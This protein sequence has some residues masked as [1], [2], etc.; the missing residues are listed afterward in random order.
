MEQEILSKM[1]AAISVMQRYVELGHSLSCAYSGGKDSTCTLVLMLEAIRRAGGTTITHHVQS[2]DTTIE[3][4]TIANFLHSVLD[5]LQ[6]YI[7]ASALPVHIHVTTPSLAS[8]FVV[9][10]IGRGTLVRTP[11]NGVRDGRRTRACAD[12]WKVRPGGRLR[13]LLERRAADDGAREVITVLGLR[14]DE[15]TSRAVAMAERRDSAETAVRS[16]TGALTISPLSEWTSDDVWT[17]LALLADAQTLL[18]PSPL[19]SRTILRLSEIYRAGNG[20]TCGVVMGESGA[21]AACGSRF[22]CS[23]CCVAGDRDKSLEAMIE[24]EQYGHLRPLNDFRNYLL[25]IQWD[26]SRRELIG[27]SLSDACYTRI[28]ADTYSYATRIGLLKMLISIDAA[29]RDRA[30]AHSADLAIG[31]I[32]DTE[33]NRM[34]CEPQFE[35]VTPQQLVAIDFFLSMHHYAP[36]AFPA[37]AVWHDVNVLGRRYPVPK[38][39]GLPK[40]DIVLHGWYPVGQ[41]DRDAPSVGLRSFDAEQWNPYRHP[42]RPG[43]YARTTGGEQTVYFEEATQFEVDAEAACAFVTCTYDTAFMLDTQHRDAIDSAHFWLNEGIVKL[44]TGM[45]QRYQDMAKRG[46]YFSRL[47]QRLNL[48][49]PELDAHLIENAIGDEAHQALFGC[50]TTQLSLFAEAA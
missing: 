40:T 22:G 50:D 24:D 32:A 9:S 44:P 12:E 1:E 36:H 6:L 19:M 48:T 11:E 26:I 49:P 37:L 13:T 28:Q 45:A 14:R 7:E 46:Q 31:S 5:E 41:Y 17:M 23:F 35:F 4:P 16:R 8:Q 10:T 18:F 42:G 15:S 30:E 33:Q 34:L 25:A 38:I 27:R 39:D 21:R 3:N 2:V 20:G 43:R 29:E 47:A